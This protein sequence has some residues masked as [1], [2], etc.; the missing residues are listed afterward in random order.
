MAHDIRVASARLV[1]LVVPAWV[2]L[3]VGTR[4]AVASMRDSSGTVHGCYS[5]LGA[6]KEASG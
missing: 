4:L 1:A 2:G 3:I 5:R 6:S